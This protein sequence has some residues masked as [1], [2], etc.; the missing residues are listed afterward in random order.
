MYSTIPIHW[1]IKS[2]SASPG[3]SRVGPALYLPN[4]QILPICDLTEREKS[5]RKEGEALQ[6][7]CRAS[8]IC[9][10]RMAFLDSIDR[11]EIYA[12]YKMMSRRI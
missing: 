6:T 1:N 3:R 8:L 2:A 12:E 11:K 9:T 10:A 7:T 5:D 4:C